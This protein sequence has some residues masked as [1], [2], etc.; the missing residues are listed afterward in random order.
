MGKR[1]TSS[2]LTS[3]ASHKRM[4]LFT[5]VVMLS[6]LSGFLPTGKTTHG[7][8]AP[9]AVLAAK[10]QSDATLLPRVSPVAVSSQVAETIIDE[11]VATPTPTPPQ[12]LPTVEPTDVNVPASQWG[13]ATQVDAHTWTMQINQDTVMATPQDIFAAL[14]SYRQKH[15]SGVLSWDQGL[16]NYAGE[17]AAFFT[18]Q[19][20]LDEHAGFTDFLN[21]QDGFKKLGYNSL[22]ENSSIGYRLEGVHL[23]EWVYAG[24]A[25][26][27]DNQLN[28]K[29]SDVGIG[30]SGTATDLIFGG[31]RQ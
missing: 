21:N 2:L 17:R 18:A 4:L 7:L 11:R 15:G 10:Q 31:S 5:G 23:I 6:Y 16:A 19:G 1:T 28:P 13:V 8:P 26:H 14:N 24:D 29:W 9:R 27:N 22:G 3:A 20:K 30:V 12:S 25:A